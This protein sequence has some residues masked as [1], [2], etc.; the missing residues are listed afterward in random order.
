MGF[1]I[2]RRTACDQ[3]MNRIYHYAARRLLRVGDVIEKAA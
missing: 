2:A 3:A 1:P